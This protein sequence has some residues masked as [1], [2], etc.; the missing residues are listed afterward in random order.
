VPAVKAAVRRAD[1][2]ECR[3]LASQAVA[4]GSAAEVR[5]LIARR[6]VAA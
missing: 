5:A 4:L 1:Y 6:G 2:V 3:K